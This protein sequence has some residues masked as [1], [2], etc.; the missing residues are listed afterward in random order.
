GVDRLPGIVNYFIGNDP[1]KWQ[2]RIP[3]YARVQYENVYP[4]IGLIYYGNQQ[5]LEYDFQVAPG[6]DPGQIR[7]VF[8]AAQNLSVD[9]SGDLVVQVHGQVLLQ[10]A[11]VV[12][13]DVAGQRRQVAAGFVV[14]GQQVGF[15]LGGYDRS[16]P[17][18]IDPVLSYSTY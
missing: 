4:G 7:L 13:E 14:Q 1:S 12:F 16:Q 8:P 9:A 17:V 2:T 18:V 3:T 5:Q 6:A 15:A 11:P 10:H